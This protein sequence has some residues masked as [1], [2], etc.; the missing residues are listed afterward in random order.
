MAFP[1][2]TSVVTNNITTLDPEPNDV[3]GLTAA[4][5]QAKFDQFGIDWIDWFINTFLPSLTATNTGSSASENLGS[6]VITGVT[7]TT[8]HDQLVALKAAIDALVVGLVP[9]GSIGV[10]QLNFDPATQTELDAVETALETNYQAAD[11]SIKFRIYMG[12]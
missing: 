9:E 3:G 1:S 10:E 6:A 7:G 11:T 8:I 5:L 2:P 4:E 12:V